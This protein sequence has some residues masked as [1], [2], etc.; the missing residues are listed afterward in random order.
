MS[1]NRFITAAL[2]GR[3]DLADEPAAPRGRERA[4]VFVNLAVLAVLVVAAVVLLVLA[5]VGL[6]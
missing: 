6:L 5:V 3:Q 1:L 4:A 2:E